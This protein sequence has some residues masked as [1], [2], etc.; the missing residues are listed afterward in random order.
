MKKSWTSGGGDTVFDD[1]VPQ[2]FGVFYIGPNT[3][4]EK[5]IMEDSYPR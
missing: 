4:L 1:F 3:D 2:N 5:R